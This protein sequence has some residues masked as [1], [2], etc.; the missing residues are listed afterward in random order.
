MSELCFPAASLPPVHAGWY[1]VSFANEIGR[2]L[3]PLSIGH[4]DLLALRDRDVIRVF[5][6][7][8]PHRG[9]HLGHGGRFAKGAVIC[10]FHGKRIGLG[11]P[12]RLAVAEHQVLRAGDAVFVRL[13]GDPGY[14]RGF[15]QVISDLAEE[16]CFIGFLT[17]HVPVPPEII[18]E[19]AFDVEHFSAVH[20]VPHVTGMEIKPG[21]TGE[22]VIEGQ[23]GSA[24]PFWDRTQDGV[25]YNRFHD[26]AYSP[27][28]VVGEFGPSDR[29]HI[30]IT[31]AIPAPGGCIVRFVLAIRPGQMGEYGDL[32]AGAR[33]A[34]RQDF[35][36]WSHLD[37]TVT[38]RLDAADAA[39]VAFRRFCAEF[40]AA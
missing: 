39:V 6:A 9:A 33:H 4:R 3:T 17:E 31:T 22:L 10:P 35:K 37:L 40:P 7:R 32:A 38:P 24:P 36:V 12:G 20:L 28:I 14:D 23:F 11:G 1:L 15:R 21:E 8:C 2:G 34:F 13:S 26:R 16:R 5:D 18:V 27:S 29:S 19:N 30:V 25:V